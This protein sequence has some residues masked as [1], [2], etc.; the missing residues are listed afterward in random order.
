[1]GKTRK[2]YRAR[3]ILAL[4][5]A[6]AMTVTMIPQTALAA[7]ADEAAAVSEGTDGIEVAEENKEV[8]ADSGA[9]EAE[10]A[11]ADDGTENNGIEGDG[12]TVVD[13]PDAED[14]VDIDSDT[15]DSNT[16]SVDQKTAG[17]DN[18]ADEADDVMP[19]A[20]TAYTILADGV[21][22]TAVYTG[23]EVFADALDQVILRTTVDGEASEQSG[24]D[25]GVVCVWKE[26]GADG[27]WAPMASGTPINAGSYQ[28]VFSYK[29][30]GEGVQGSAEDVTV[31]FEIT[32]ASVTIELSSASLSVTPGTAKEKVPTP[33]ISRV[34][35]ANYGLDDTDI[36]LS[37]S[38]IRDAVTGDA[39]ED[40]TALKKNG[41]YVMDITPAFSATASENK[42]NNYELTAFT[43]DIVMA[44]L[45]TTQVVVKVADKWK[46]ESGEFVITKEYDKNPMTAPKDSGDAPDYTYEVQIEDASAPEG[47]KKLENAV[48]AGEWEAYDGCETGQDGKV[49]APVNAGLYSYRVAYAGEDGVYTES[50]TRINVEITPAQLTVEATGK[51]P[52]KVLEGTT[53]REALSGLD[54]KVTDKSGK[55]VT[56]DAKKNHIWGTGFDDSNVSQIYEPLFTLQEQKD[57]KWQDID[58][59]DYQLVGGGTYR[60]V[61]K[62]QKAIFNADGTYSHRT[63]VNDSRNINGVDGNYMTVTEPTADDK[64]LTVEVTPGTEAEIDVSKLLDK[65]KET[66]AELAT[67]SKEYDGKPLYETRSQYKNN[68]GLK[69]KDGGASIRTELREF[70]F[71]WEKYD[72]GTDLLDAQ[73]D[74]ENQKNGLQDGGP[75]D[76]SYWEDISDWTNPSPADVGVYRLKI[77]YE[78]KLDDDKLNYVKEPKVVYFAI[79]PKQ[80]QIVPEVPEEGYSA[81]DGHTIGSFFDMNELKGSIQTLDGKPVTDESVQIGWQI[82]ETVQRTAGTDVNEYNQHDYANNYEYFYGNSDTASY[83]YVLRGGSVL[84]SYDWDVENSNYTCFSSTKGYE[85]G[86]APQRAKRQDTPLN[87][88]VAPI[89]VKPMGTTELVVAVDAAKWGVKEKE[90]DAKPFESTDLV[91][92]GLVTVKKKADNAAV[93]DAELVYF[94]Y[95]ED[96]DGYRYTRS[97]EYIVD[98]GSYD[99][100]VRFDGSETYSPIGY[101]EGSDTKVNLWE[102]VKVGTFKIN[103]REITLKAALEESYTAGTEVSN[104]VYQAQESLIVSGA[105][106]EQEWAFTSRWDSEEETYYV[107]AWSTYEEDYW[108]N[109][110]SP[111]FAVYEK[112]S[113]A[114]LYEWDTIRRG[115]SYEVRYDENGPGL[116]CYST[117]RETIDFA[118]N[119]KVSGNTAAE[120]AAVPGNSTITSVDWPYYEDEDSIKEIAI[121]V[122]NDEKDSMKREV[123]MVEGIGYASLALDDGT[124]IEGNLVAF[125]ITAPAE[126]GSMPQTAMY[127]NVIESAKV[128]GHVVDEGYY[129]FTAVFDAAEGDK[130]FQIRWEDGYVETY[131]LK[132]DEAV[133]LGNLKEAVAPKSLA[134][135][136]PNKKMAVGE[137][138]QL[139]VKITKGQMGDVICL[140][141]ESD[142]PQVLAV[143]EDGSVTA[144][145]IGSATVKAFPQRYVKGKLEQIPG[146][147][148]ASVK[149]QVTKLTAPKKVKTTVRGTSVNLDYDTPADGYRREIYVVKKDNSLKNAAQFENLLKGMKENQWKER[150]VIEPVYLDEADEALNRRKGYTAKLSGLDVNTDYTIYVRNVCAARTLAD[151]SV[152][153][154]EAVDASAAGT[155]ANMK[156][157]KT[158]IVGMDFYVSAPQNAWD[159]DEDGYHRLMWFSGLKN[160][161][162]QCTPYGYFPAVGADPAADENDRIRIAIPFA[163][164][165]K[166]KYKDIYEEPKLEYALKFASESDDKYTMKNSAASIDK[167]G[168]IKFTGIPGDDNPIKVRMRDTVTGIE[169]FAYISFRDQADS[170]V[171]AKKSVSLSVGQSQRLGE[172]LAYKLG[173][174]KLTWYSGQWLDMDAVNSAVKEQ[175]QEAYFRV[176]GS[177]LTAIQK[178]GNLKLKL[179][180]KN[181]EKVS[182]KEKAT[183]EVTIKTADL[184]AIKKLKAYDVIHDRFGLQF[185][186]AGY[187]DEFLLEISDA[188]KPIYSK[189]V[190]RYEEIENAYKRDKDGYYVYD[191]DGEYI[192]IKDTYEI[193]PATIKSAVKLTK[194]TQYTVKLTPVYGDIKAKT[195]TAKAKTTKIPV[196]DGW[197]SSA[198]A[199]GCSSGISIK[200]SE[201]DFYGST[202]SV[203]SGNTYTLTANV[204]YNRGRVNDTLVWKVGNAKVASVKAAAG[205]YCIT[206]KGLKPGYTTLEVRSKILGNKVIARYGIDVVAVGDAY[207]DGVAIRYYGDNEPE[208]MVT[209]A[210]PGQIGNGEP[211]RLP[212]SVDDP[213]KVAVGSRESFS[214]RA[215]ETGR[216]RVQAITADLSVR[217]QVSSSSSTYY[218]SMDLGWIQ[219]G[220]S[221]SLTSQAYYSGYADT[222]YYIVVTQEQAM[223]EAGAGE[224]QI[225]VSGYSV[226]ERFRFTPSEDGDYQFSLVDKDGGAVYLYLYEQESDAIGQYGGSVDASGSS[227]TYAL[228]KNT[229]V[230][231]KTDDLS[232]Y[233]GPYMLK[234]EK[235]STTTP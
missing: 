30:E 123:T 27:G 220:E 31:D 118:R 55:D 60:V 89:T 102:G 71:T 95:E 114:A 223:Q 233:Y 231:L 157:R 180:D 139:D 77:S 15:V 22:Q 164:D 125:E 42:K 173:S 177:Y 156:T 159:Y 113:K 84:Y 168:K 190:S 79:D 50:E 218:S 234:I 24:R 93:E 111:S 82:V 225:E 116:G 182:G 154:K 44:D 151:G 120:F 170:V 39:V 148:T 70:T 72:Y 206:L 12:D 195:A 230:W 210:E 25:A 198:T 28:A 145:A 130:E 165:D 205:T 214:F 47:W 34:D 62:G 226:Q 194:E 7:T 167:K 5:L 187:A 126:Y 153:T 160:G 23:W 37:V 52:L 158:E 224:T 53:M 33:V 86:P 96:E 1:M 219:A 119:Y 132:F 235:V 141:Y 109:L 147:K 138:Q 175:G 98:A 74:D 166:K 99:L 38:G 227:F 229:P 186:Y 88:E 133:K 128:N 100:Y 110:Q 67:A 9:V 78:D 85:E 117:W 94:V 58:D 211:S 122:K 152:I 26:K 184:T 29:Q 213:R 97:L 32:K 149:I 131:K 135:N 171:A 169:K 90:Y 174:K 92:E 202:L 87:T 150:F 73:I 105:V 172:L 46:T 121:R 196:T 163:G 232:R 10:D 2:R 137:S 64:A 199:L 155:V 142:N 3:R 56:G 146:A 19:M 6:A 101:V 57:G 185:T 161:V 21:E 61:Y 91:T 124:D 45:I 20:E 76:D 136:A 81:L 222:S 63:D 176:S 66:F 115:K 65:G 162:V 112:N 59:A 83:S 14:I 228:T 204:K 188:K 191:K 40:G 193:S 104:L 144:L 106:P 8:T 4:M 178:G 36:T 51:S 209:P 69:A 13:D 221:V 103:P 217:F 54:C 68:V 41:D 107:P 212:L 192:P 140:G 179:T 129:G 16:S 108:E 203:L 134:F 35:C 201:R 17:E 48:T 215:P 197:L 183:A 75:A 49:P 80:V 216:Y 43:A 127:R 189:V 181:V 143:N 18:A 208:N 11:A 207:D 200:V